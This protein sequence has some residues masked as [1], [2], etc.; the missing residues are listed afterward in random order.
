[1]GEGDVV[2]TAKF[3]GAPLLID[4]SKDSKVFTF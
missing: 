4:L 2:E 1:V 3:A